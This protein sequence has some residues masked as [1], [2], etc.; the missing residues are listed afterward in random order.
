MSENGGQMSTLL[1]EKE[2]EICGKFFQTDNKL[3]KLCDDC[4]AHYNSRRR[5][6]DRCLRDSKRRLDEPEVI[7]CTCC[8]C[9]KKYK[10]IPKLLIKYTEDKTRWGETTRI[11][12]SP[13]C[14]KAYRKRYLKNT[15]VCKYCGE[16]LKDK[17]F[18]DPDT[19]YTDNQYCS[20]E[21]KDLYKR[22]VAEE[23]GMVRICQNCGKEF[24]RKDGYFCSQK[25]SR[26][27]QKNGWVSPS[28]IEPKKFV[29]YFTCPVCGL[30]YERHSNMQ[31]P[32]A[33]VYSERPCSEECK[34][35][36][37]TKQK[38]KKQQKLSTARAKKVANKPSENLC[39]T[40]KVS[41]KDCERMQSNFRIL[42]KGAHYD[43]KGMLVVCPKY[44]A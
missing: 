14:K 27:A 37:R 40:C 10:T 19:D 8:E 15:Q 31:Q 38:E 3:R 11:F 44:I 28:R 34:E 12:C 25:C 18:Y 20:Q 6:Y 42:P 5:D 29:H 17:P 43:K 9:G 26:E 13:S 7:E 2:C 1:D 33:E 23:M 32:P 4:S 36:Y 35:K 30:Q 21:H 41:Y 24:I 22:K 16:P 39:A